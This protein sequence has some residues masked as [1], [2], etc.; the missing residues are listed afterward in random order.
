MISELK[1]NINAHIKIIKK[2]DVCEITI[3]GNSITLSSLL[4][5]AMMNTP[6]FNFIVKDALDSYI[7][8]KAQLN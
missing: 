1:D 8:Y 5:T 4:F 2:E 3:S 7:S 6:D